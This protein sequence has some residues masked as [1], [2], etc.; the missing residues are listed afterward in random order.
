MSYLLRLLDSLRRS[1]FLLKQ[2]VVRDF[3]V[4]YKRSMLG[5][6]WSLL[7]PLLTTAVLALVFSNVFR[8]SAPGVSYVAY[9]LTG[10]VCFNYFSEASNLC[11]SS[12]AAN[13]SLIGKVY[14]PKYI[15]PISKCLF[16]G[17]NFLLT[18]IPLYLV[19]LITGTGLCWQHLLLP[20]AFACL[21]LFTLGVGFFLAAAAVFFRD[22]Y[23]IYGIVLTLWLYLTPVM[24]DPA[25][26]G[27]PLLQNLIALNP[28]YAP[29]RFVRTV[30]LYHETPGIGQFAACAVHGALALAVGSL[31]F[32]RTQDKF[33][34]YL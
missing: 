15:F 29:I 21:F 7:Y 23:Y 2:L 27:Q 14:V 34:C 25:V 12:I 9:L 6:A 3:K 20:Y 31:L 18:L 28:L 19:L 11:M 30:M 33:V 10:L 1:R 8:F 5:V 4:K 22:V 32:K 13:Y 24:Y 26:I 16:V 17:V